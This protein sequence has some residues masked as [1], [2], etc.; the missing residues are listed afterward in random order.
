MEGKKKKNPVRVLGTQAKGP[1][2]LQV[3]SLSSD[4]EL[5][6]GAGSSSWSLKGAELWR[7]KSARKR[8]NYKKGKGVLKIIDIYAKKSCKNMVQ[9]VSRWDTVA[10]AATARSTV[11]ATASP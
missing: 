8:M 2:E 1:R 11:A 10:L 3:L 5:E 4:M 7:G 6:L 9:V